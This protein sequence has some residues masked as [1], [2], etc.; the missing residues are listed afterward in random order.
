MDDLENN[1]DGQATASAVANEPANPMLEPLTPAEIAFARGEIK[2]PSEYKAPEGTTSE[3]QADRASGASEQ[4]GKDSATTGGSNDAA[5]AHGS[6]EQK[7][8]WITDDVK[9]TAAM[10][11]LSDDELNDFQD[12]ADLD[13]FTRRYDRTLAK[14]GV[15]TNSGMP[16]GQEQTQQGGAA[17]QQQQTAGQGQTGQ[18]GQISLDDKDWEGYDEKTQALVKFNRSLNDKMQQLEQYVAHQQQIAFT[19][20]FHDA[21]DRLGDKRLGTS[22]VNGMATQLSGDPG[23]LRERL[24]EAAGQLQAGIVAQAQRAGKQP[25]IPPIGILVKRA[26]NMLFADDIQTAAKADAKKGLLKQ[27][28]H[29]RPAEQT[30][31]TNLTPKPLPKDATL[32]QQVEYVANLPQI[33]EGF[34]RLQAT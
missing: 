11:G 14:A 31:R 18:A 16:A 1:T 10:Y 23:Q 7:P 30:R 13:R 9:L 21:V 22:I 17:G 25:E 29:V 4:P 3:S 6:N 8:T 27:A 20:T 32:Q 5:D 26:Y 24:F 33:V 12:K 2:H 19:N 28:A 15:P 34:E